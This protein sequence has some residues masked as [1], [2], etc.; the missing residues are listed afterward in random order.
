[1][2]FIP[3][4]GEKMIA[5]NKFFTGSVSDPR[6][7]IDVEVGESLRITDVFLSKN[8][9]R[10]NV[11]KYH[12]IDNMYISDITHEV[13]FDMNEPSEVVYEFK[14]DDLN[15]FFSRKD[16][17]DIIVSEEDYLQTFINSNK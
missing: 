10:I 12:I 14:L 6:S 9:R 11:D 5:I 2:S 17:Y 1:M 8:S 7:M 13:Q 3:I 4:K 16:I 15:H